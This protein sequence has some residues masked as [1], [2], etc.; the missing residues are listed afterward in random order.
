[1]SDKIYE[2]TPDWQKRAF[3]D[4]AKYKEMYA[5]S[6]A[7]PNTFWG[8]QGKR[9]DWI[10]PYTKVKN[11]SYDPH[12]VSIKWFED[13][14]LN[15]AYNCIDR[16]LAKR[17][18]QT[19]IIWEGDDPKDSKTVTYKQLHAEVCKFANVLKAQ[20]VKKGD[21]VTIY[22]PMIVEA[23]YAMLACARIGA[24]HSVVF[25]GFSPDSIAGR[26]EDCTSTVIV[27]ADEGLRGGRKIPLKANIDAACD[28]AGGVTSVIV[29]KRTGA[30]VNM[31]AGRDVYYDEAA[32]DGVRR[33]PLRGDECGG[34]AVHPLHLGL[35]RKSEGRAAHHRWLCR[36]HVDDASI[37]VRLSRR[38]RLLVHR[39]CRL[40]H[41]PQLHRL[42]PAAERRDHADV[43]GRAELPD[44]FAVL[45]GHRQAQ[46]QHLLHRADRD[47]RADAGRR[48]AGEED[49]ACVAATARL[50]RRAD[51]SGSLGMVLPRG[52]RRPLPDRRYLVADRDRRHSDHAAA[53]RDRAEARFGD[54]AVLRRAS[55]RSSMPRAR[56]STAPP[57]AISASPIRGPARCARSM[58]TISVSSTP[59]S[60]PIPASISPATA[61]GATPTAITGSPAGSTTSSTSR[62]T[63]WARRKWNPRWWRIRKCRKPPWSAIR[64]TSRARASMPMSP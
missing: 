45:G 57:P 61:A 1:M 34:S 36:L 30:P 42:W 53:G 13:G 63:A 27:T 32:K 11:T 29:V 2:V 59:I 20:G 28:K 8:E 50:G 54:P 9:V 35:D 6:I 19:A 23:A 33:L 60:A 26:I 10:K 64:I 52:R 12:N 39:R 46:G 17:G 41:R 40:G 38:R 47:P 3:I 5:A 7:D 22:L 48:R 15:L 62:A 18:D 51:Q 58:A 56:C 16:H 24:V 49:L 4:H 37:R 43:R 14:S 44:Q 55:R 21:R 31:K 25:G